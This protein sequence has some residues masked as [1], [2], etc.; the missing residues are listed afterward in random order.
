MSD[1]GITELKLARLLPDPENVNQHN[2]QNIQQ[3]MASISRFGF[4]DPIGVVK[5]ET[6]RGYYTIVEGH[7]RFEAATLLE[8]E[9]VPCLVLSMDD[10]HRRG[11]AIAHNQ[12]QQ[13]ASMDHKAVAMEFERLDVAPDDYVSLGYT[14]EDVLFLPGMTQG[15]GSMH[16][17][18]HAGDADGEGN[19]EPEQK[20]ETANPA[21]GFAPAVHRTAL[22]FSTD[23]SYNRFVHILTMLRSRYPSAG[24]IGE[25]LILLLGEA[26]VTTPTEEGADA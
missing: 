7:G 12:T 14:Q 9:T 5:H 4:L 18:F 10:A 16:S 22:T 26:G 21:S 2:E 20:A 17:H 23:Q 13:I 11:Y 19:G 1:N 25:R 3:I 15:P 8:I 6:R 24:T